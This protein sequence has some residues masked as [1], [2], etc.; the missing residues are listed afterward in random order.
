LNGYLSEVS[1]WEKLVSADDQTLLWNDG[2][3]L[4]IY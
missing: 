1:I 4:E 2:D 3:G